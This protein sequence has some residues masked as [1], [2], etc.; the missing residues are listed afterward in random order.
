MQGDVD[1]HIK[2]G[3]INFEIEIDN[4]T[5]ITIHM[6]PDKAERCAHRMLELISQIKSNKQTVSH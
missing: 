5:K 3:M 6:P 1:L 4:G 2:N